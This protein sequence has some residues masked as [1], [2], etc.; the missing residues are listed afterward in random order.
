M[1]TLG[2]GLIKL[3]LGLGALTLIIDSVLEN[4]T[5]IL[6]IASVVTAVIVG[7]IVF[8]TIAGKIR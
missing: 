3:M 5:D 1:K 6:S 4:S 8:K 7:S 2:N